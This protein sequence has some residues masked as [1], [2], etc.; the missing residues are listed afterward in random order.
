MSSGRF[1]GGLVIGSLVGAAIA[2]LTAPRTGK[3][4][5]DW[6]AAEGKDRFGNV[7]EELQQQLN[8]LKGRFDDT[9]SVTRD[10]ANE[11]MDQIKESF[12]KLSHQV[13]DSAKAIASKF[14]NKKPD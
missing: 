3:E 4:N 14:N 8:T 6:L 9:S 11:A 1:L 13:E 5:R 12:G 2:L 10:K 7:S